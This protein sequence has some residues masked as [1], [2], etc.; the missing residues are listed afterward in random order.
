MTTPDHGILVRRTRP[1]EAATFKAFRLRALADTPDAFA[2][3]TAQ[4][5]AMPWERWVHRVTRG[6]IGEEALLLV[7]VDADTNAWLGM[8]GSYF[9]DDA[10]HTAH[11]VSVWTAPEAR[12]RGVARL[13]QEAARS[14]AASRG[15]REQRLWV[16]NTNDAARLLYEAEGFALTGTTQPHPANPHLSELEMV[17][18]L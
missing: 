13:L 12:R 3:T 4:A 11:I 7:A 16:T 9:K 6:A 2:T 1:D 10:P 5:E 8:T 15:A 17:R 18:P 14:W